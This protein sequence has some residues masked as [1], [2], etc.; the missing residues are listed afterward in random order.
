MYSRTA[1]GPLPPPVG[2]GAPSGNGGINP[3]GMYNQ[4]PSRNASD[5]LPPPVGG[6][7]YS[8]TGGINPNGMYDQPPSRNAEDPLPPTTGGGSGGGEDRSPGWRRRQNVANGTA[9]FP[10]AGGGGRRGGGGGGQQGGGGGAG[11][12]GGGTGGAD[13]TST[14]AVDPGV[15]GAI[16]AL[17][18]ATKE[19]MA[20][21][22]D[23]LTADTQRM[24][25]VAGSDIS[26]RFAGAGESL[27]ADMARRGIS[28]SG[29]EGTKR[30]DLSE[31]SQRA[32]ARSTADITMRQQERQD[33]M[34]LARTGMA[35]NLLTAGVNASVL[36]AQLAL[37]QQG[38]GLQQMGLAQGGQNM[39]LQAQL[40]RDRMAQQDRQFQAGL[41]LQQQQQVRNSNP[42]A[43]SQPTGGGSSRGP[44]RG[45][46]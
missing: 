31:A 37:Q 33:E 15:Q 46:W 17:N 41:S 36:P 34:N 22:K 44:V 42:W 30:A 26:D 12:A 43:V 16:G 3:G 25:N 6:G 19:Q 4:P 38:L 10:N 9:G 13:V 29:V 32:Q 8:G 39:S 35:N 24:I 14:S 28:G 45:G 23:P 11:G 5:P 40:E 2:G 21:A 1:G 18:A 27:A 7:G 20:G